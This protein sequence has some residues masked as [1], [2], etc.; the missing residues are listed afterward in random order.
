MVFLSSALQHNPG[1]SQVEVVLIY[2]LLVVLRAFYSISPKL[3][4]QLD[5]RHNIY[6]AKTYTLQLHHQSKPPN[7]F[8]A[9]QGSL[10][11]CL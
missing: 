5:Q 7:L 3:R 2:L 8:I 4:K 6:I 11:I 9:L 1:R 10:S